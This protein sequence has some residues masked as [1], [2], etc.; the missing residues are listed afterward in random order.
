M[1]FSNKN[2]KTPTQPLGVI[3]TP[4]IKKVR[5]EIHAL[6][7][8]I[9]KNSNISR[10]QVYKKISKILG[11]KYHTANIMSEKEAIRVME[12]VREIKQKEGW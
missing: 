3:A 10:S 12:I 1:Y 4:E 2:K 5:M 7:D 9:W 6:L 8:P 11:Y